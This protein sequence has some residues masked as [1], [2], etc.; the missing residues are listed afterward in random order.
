MQLIYELGK[1]ID[2][3][4]HCGGFP[5][6][7]Q[8]PNKNFMLVLDKSIHDNVTKLFPRYST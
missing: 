1:T 4:R 8:L 3:I 7:D 5:D 6:M 2:I